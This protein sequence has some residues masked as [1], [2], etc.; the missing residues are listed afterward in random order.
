MDFIKIKFGTDIKEIQRDIERLMDEVFDLRRP[1]ILTRPSRWIPEADIYETEEEVVIVVNL[2]GV[3]KDDIEVFL[4]DEYIYIRGIR[5]QPVEDIL[6]YHKLEIEYGEF[7][8][9]FKIPAAVD[10]ES[11]DAIWKDGFLMIRMRKYKPIPRTIKVEV[12]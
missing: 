12:R 4:Y 11:I 3:N 2:A 1:F 8:R 10:R 6:K 9:A 7:E 5:N